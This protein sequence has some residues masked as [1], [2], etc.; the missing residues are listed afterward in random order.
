MCEKV[1]E[2]ESGLDT[3]RIN[4]AELSKKGYQFIKENRLEE[5]EENFNRILEVDEENTYALVGLGDSARR[6]RSLG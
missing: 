5:A 6:R 1:D 2:I 3:I 4:I